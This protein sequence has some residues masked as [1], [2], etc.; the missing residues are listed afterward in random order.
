MWRKKLGLIEY[1]SDV[2]ALM[3]SGLEMME[4]LEIDYTIFGGS[5]RCAR[6]FVM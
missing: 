3:D 1:D 6:C 5:C 4:E 2:K